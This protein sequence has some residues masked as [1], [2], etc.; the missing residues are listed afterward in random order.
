M[1][2]EEERC[3]PASA[4]SA[5]TAA[6]LKPLPRPMRRLLPRRG[7]KPR[8]S[9]LAPVMFDVMRLLGSAPPVRA[10]VVSCSARTLGAH[11]IACIRLKVRLRG[12]CL[13]CECNAGECAS[14]V[15]RGCMMQCYI[16][17]YTNACLS[18]YVGGLEM[19]THDLLE[20]LLPTAI[21]F[22]QTVQ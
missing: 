14:V 9:V 12:R 5:S 16:T 11:L 19:P 17:I 4:L 10:R 22:L 18:T 21:Y 7:S 13:N 2:S 15:H 1:A 20:L 6:R 3:L 8:A